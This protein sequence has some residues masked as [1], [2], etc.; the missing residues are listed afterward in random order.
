MTGDGSN[1]SEKCEISIFGLFTVVLT[2]DTTSATVVQGAIRK[3]TTAVA[4]N[5]TM[6]ILVPPCGFHR[7]REKSKIINKNQ[8]QNPQ[9][10]INQLTK[11]V[12]T[13]CEVRKSVLEVKSFDRANRINRSNNQEFP[14]KSWYLKGTSGARNSNCEEEE[15]KEEKEHYVSVHEME[16]GPTSTTRM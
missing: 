10:N 14:S 15:K 5:G 3:F 13:D 9:T 12:V 4:L 1:G 11:I 6:L 16:R 2:C 7:T 8:N